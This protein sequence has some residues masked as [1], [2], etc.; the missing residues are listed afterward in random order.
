MFGNSKEYQDIK[1]LYE[2]KVSKPA[3]PENINEITGG[4]GPIPNVNSNN[5]VKANNNNNVAPKTSKNIFQKIGD[6]L[7]SKPITGSRSRFSPKGKF[8]D[9]SSEIES[10]EAEFKANEGDKFNKAFKDA[11][12]DTSKEIESSSSEFKANEG[13]KVNQRFKKDVGIVRRSQQT[14]V[15]RAQAMAN[16]RI[17][18]KKAGTY[19]KPKTAQELAK[20]RIKA[21]EAGTYK[22]PKTAQELAKERIAAKKR[23][24]D[25]NI[26][27]ENY[28][29]YDMV[30]EYLMSTQQV[31]TIE[32]ANYVMT[33][34]DAETIQ[35]IVEEQKKNLDEG[36]GRAGLGALKA[37]GR[38][39]AK[40]PTNFAI[41][42]AGTGLVGQKVVKPVVTKLANVLNKPKSNT[43]NFN[44]LGN[45]IDKKRNE[46]GGGNYRVDE[47]EKNAGVE[48][49]FAGEKIYFNKKNKK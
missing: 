31:A 21:K 33:E 28:T 46:Q 3:K 47:V 17:A 20:E 7:K 37:I 16:K 8:K 13:D 25:A 22:K 14:G 29:P 44:P 23:L 15:Q 1:K 43:N 2:E 18:D 36:L 6:V 34:M 39:G 38:F 45:F 30:L 35:S 24:S 32:E 49:G 27:V 10:S 40:N 42:M 4:L 19:Q 9:T 41:T 26:K 12:T 5:N 48:S 11:N